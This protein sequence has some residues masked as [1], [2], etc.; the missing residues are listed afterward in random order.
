[1]A[2]FS[3]FSINRLSSPA[4]SVTN[5][6][7]TAV[8]LASL[9][10]SDDASSSLG[11]DEQY[12]SDLNSNNSR[13]AWS[14]PYL[15]CGYKF[16]YIKSKGTYLALLW[17]FLVFI[18]VSGIYGIFLDALAEDIGFLREGYA[19]KLTIIS[20][21]KTAAWMLYPFAGWMADTCFGRYKTIRCSLY[22]LWVGT[23]VF[24]VALECKHEYV[25]SPN[26]VHGI[27]YGV[28]PV[29]IVAVLIA[30]AGFQANI[31]PFGTDQMPGASGD[32]LASFT[33]WYLW[34]EYVGV[35]IIYTVVLG[36]AANKSAVHTAYSL[37][38]AACMTIAVCLDYIFS[39]IFI[40]EPPCGNPFR[41][42]IKVLRY[43]WSNNQQGPRSAL[44]YWED[45]RLS[46]FDM[47]KR[48]YGGIFESDKVESVQTTL[49]IIAVLLAFILSAT[50][51]GA[52]Q[53][54][55]G[56][57]V[58]HLESGTNQSSTGSSA[59]LF[60]SL[61][62]QNL[63]VSNIYLI[64]ITV[65]VPIVQFLIFPVFRNCIPS[66]LKRIGLGHLLLFMSAASLLVIDI[67]GRVNSHHDYS[68]TTTNISCFL[69]ADSDPNSLKLD[70]P[71]QW[72]AIPNVLFG[73]AYM[74]TATAVLEFI[75]AQAPHNMK[76]FLIGIIFSIV[77]TAISLGYVILIV[78]YL[79]FNYGDSYAYTGCGTWYFSVNSLISLA[80]FV[81]YCVVSVWYR[82]RVRDD[83]SFEQI[84]V[85][86]YYET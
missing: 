42:I 39:G 10:P 53:G 66:T 81:L 32:E 34:S 57:I 45:K 17:N 19:W 51:Y 47:A 64:V 18:C 23:I 50:T 46:R 82:P 43:V 84:H 41:P 4:S 27:H 62:Y 85:E 67:I 86:R 15:S 72:L 83:V 12:S 7:S 13:P 24:A 36:C 44:T 40:I 60:T 70:V 65:A 48:R 76:G 20:F 26:I 54:I 16:I 6:N 5:I 52:L 38:M 74:S 55:S 58:S 3:K 29:I 61:C 80:G 14:R 11:S 37:L 59:S 78:F 31:V 79:G 22:L 35:G 73:L 9:L 21:I 2:S 1:M 28:Y 77:G 30:L 71:F 63:A 69:V 33:Q 25:E 68:N 75:C 56:Q 49:R 8:S